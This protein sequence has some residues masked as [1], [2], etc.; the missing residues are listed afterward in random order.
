MKIAYDIRGKFLEEVNKEFVSYLVK[1]LPNEFILA[2]DGTENSKKVY[3]WL[4][5]LSIKEGKTIF[6]LGISTT[7]F[8]SFSGYC[9]N[10]LSIMVTASHLGKEFTGFKISEN[11]VSWEKDKYLE[12]MEKIEFEKK[13]KDDRSEENVGGESKVGEGKIINVFDNVLREYKENWLNLNSL[14]NEEIEIN[15]NEKHCA[16]KILDKLFKK[17][18][19]SKDSIISFDTD[20]DR[21]YLIKK[22][23]LFPD[24][25]G[26]VFAK[27]LTKEGDKII[28]NVGCSVLVYKELKDRNLEMVKTGRNIVIQAMKD[29]KFGFEYSGHFY[30]SNENYQLDDGIKAFIEFLKIGE[31][32][33]L[34][35]YE[36]LLKKTNLSKEYRVEGVLD[37]FIDLVN[38]FKE[39]AFRIIDI[40][41]YRLEFGNENEIEGFLLI[42]Q[43]NTENKVSIRFEHKDKEFFE[44]IKEKVEEKL[45]NLN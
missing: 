26:I 3:E 42:R 30:F 28:F 8:T 18:E 45:K 23:K 37:D 5:E 20:A 39:K 14:G 38:E 12:L 1:F 29:A 6:D 24:L 19:L 44:K 35:E 17:V 25:V 2:F 31:K 15:L 41:G 40:D 9:L 11:G 13:K 10:K 36:R 34:E 33:F 22:E 43:S 21:F 27:Y 7:P 32:R 16:L 4:K